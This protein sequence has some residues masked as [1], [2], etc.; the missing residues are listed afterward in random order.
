MGNR[1]IKHILFVIVLLCQFTSK[2]SANDR[3][4]LVINSYSPDFDWSVSA[5]QGIKST[6]LENFPMAEFKVRYLNSEMFPNMEEWLDYIP[7]KIYRTEKDNPIAIVLISDEA[8]LAYQLYYSKQFEGVPV[9]L[10]FV[11]PQTICVENFIENR[12]VEDYVVYSTSDL[13][14]K[15]PSTGV[16]R[17]VNIEGTIDLMQRVVKDMNRIVLLGD[18]RYYAS[19]VRYVLDRY[20]R[21]N[22]LT[23][24]VD[25]YLV[26]DM[27]K[28]DLLADLSTLTKTTGVLLSMWQDG[29]HSY[30]YTRDNTYRKMS[31]N[32]S[33]PIFLTIDLGLSTGNFLGGV[34]LDSYF[35]GEK[36]GNQIVRFL[37][38]RSVHSI[39]IETYK[40]KIPQVNWEVAKSF[41]V[42]KEELPE[43]TSFRFSS[44]KLSERINPLVLYLVVSFLIVILIIIWVF[45][46]RR[47][48]NKS[49]KE[50]KN[51]YDN[52]MLELSCSEAKVDEFRAYRA[53]VESKTEIFLLNLQNELNSAYLKREKNSQWLS[54]LDLD[55]ANRE[56]LTLLRQSIYELDQI[57]DVGIDV[58]RLDSVPCDLV[59]ENVDLSA[60]CQELIGGLSISCNGDVMLSFLNLD[61]LFFVKTD[62]SL[63]RKMINALLLNSIRLCLKGEIVLSCR[64]VGDN[65]MIGI[66][67][68]GE[69]R[70][71]RESQLINSSEGS[72]N[73]NVGLSVIY[74][75]V[76]SRYLK[77]AVVVGDGLSAYTIIIPVDYDSLV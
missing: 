32:L 17:E 38:G 7:K 67:H 11:K 68:L 34:F 20:V 43:N 50:L 12:E 35:L 60:L 37:R 47:L 42:N 26:G 19:Y 70:S 71:I 72:H 41:G 6:V 39:E 16:F 74:A 77:S 10:C 8:W 33:V 14:K 24:S 55:E 25:N 30:S 57:K 69:F 53:N 3:E 36:T 75:R 31:D 76:I 29:T 63:L 13:M 23:Y 46:Q 59:I 44:K 62:A 48:Y 65:V 51:K 64:R 45:I 40:G 58:I 49:I 56:N 18:R 15:Y 27:T 9:F 5:I 73:N 2:L 22:A 61:P 28:E 66:E 1:F 4:I 21:D 54:T 52:L